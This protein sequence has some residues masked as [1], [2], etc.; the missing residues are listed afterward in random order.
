MRGPRVRLGLVKTVL[1]SLLPLVALVVG[2]ESAARVVEAVR[3]PIL[4]DIGMSFS[5]E[6]RLFVPSTLLPGW[7]MTSPTKAVPHPKAAHL[8]QWVQRLSET[9]PFQWQTFPIAKGTDTFRVFVVGESSV[10]YARAP[11]ED[12]LWGLK[13]VSSRQKIEVINAG[14]CGYGSTR[15]LGVVQ[16]ILSYAPDAVLLYIGHNESEEEFERQQTSWLSSAAQRV[17]WKSAAMRL[18]RDTMA[19]RTLRKLYEDDEKQDAGA[20][21][22][23]RDLEDRRQSRGEVEGQMEGFRR[24]VEAMIEACRKKAVPIVLGTIPSNLW[25]PDLA[26]LEL[27]RYEREVLPL[28]AAGEHAKGMQAAQEILC[29]A[30]RH[31]SSALE[32]GVLR[33]LAKQWELPLADVEARVIAAEPHGVPGETL[34]ADHCH[35]NGAGNEILAEVYAEEV[36]ALLS[37]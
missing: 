16:E 24:N 28:Y 17:L 14:G 7:M 10:N 22:K 35:L 34:F 36:R 11:F 26:A 32:N 6:S 29:W 30:P 20:E 18:A 25:K 5:P 8:P 12:A 27:A 37:D 31:Q 33:E 21:I 2:V 19:A 13:D 1:Y 4:V 15:L 3:P 23:H 9:V